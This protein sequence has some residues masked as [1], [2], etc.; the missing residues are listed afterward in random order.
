MNIGSGVK[1][2]VDFEWRFAGNYAQ[3]ISHHFRLSS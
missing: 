2:I 3:L 1:E